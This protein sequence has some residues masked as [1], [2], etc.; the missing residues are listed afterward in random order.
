MPRDL[1][2]YVDAFEQTVRATIEL[3]SD[4]TEEQWAHPTECPGWTVKD[5]VAHIA[6][7]E[8]H[9]LGHPAPATD[10]PDYPYV[11][12]E[13]GRLM[14]THVDARRPVSGPEIVAELAAALG[15]RLR[16]LRD[17]ELS[18]DSVMSGLFGPTPAY[19]MMSLRTFD[20]WAHEQDI[21]RALDRPGNLDSPAAAMAVSRIARALP[22]MIE[23]ELAPGQ[24][25][26]IEV[27]GAQACTITAG[28]S[29]PPTTTLTM[30]TEAFTR[31]GCGRIAA[32]NTPATIT[33]DETLGRRVLDVLAMTP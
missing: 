13:Q 9:L 17:P 31:R 15:Q 12:N 10:L 25:V 20:A 24:S 32:A 2:E 21:R 30:D 4:L 29:A 8:Q 18:A 5:Q 1:S 14:Q 16:V 6:G 27:T 28:A 22:A 11:R 3:T 23:A 33:G 7:I 19:R 26:H